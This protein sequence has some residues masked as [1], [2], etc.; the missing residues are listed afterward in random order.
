MDP[1]LKDIYFRRFVVPIVITV[2]LLCGIAVIIATPP[3]TSVKWD[4]FNTVF[5]SSAAPH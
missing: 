5:G 2:L 4:T 3:G 1:E